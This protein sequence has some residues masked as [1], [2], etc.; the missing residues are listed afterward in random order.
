MN[1]IL[2]LEN[3]N[4]MMFNHRRESQDRSLIQRVL[5]VTGSETICVKPYSLSLFNAADDRI[6]VINDYSQVNENEYFF[7]E[8]T[9]PVKFID[10]IDKVIIYRWNR[11]YPADL[12][13]TVDMTNFQLT[14]SYDFEGTSHERITEE[15]Y[16]KVDGAKK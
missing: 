8:D 13:C 10:A 5:K 6:R 2:C 12:R 7:D 14:S 16:K 11:T 9:D 4:G 15:M 1:L 3:D